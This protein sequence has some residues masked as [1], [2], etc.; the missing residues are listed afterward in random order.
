MGSPREFAALLEHVKATSWVPVIDSAFQFS[1]ADM[2]F[3]RLDHRD[4][5]GK[6]VLDT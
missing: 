4:R 1:D 6:V 5:V 2:A 3:A